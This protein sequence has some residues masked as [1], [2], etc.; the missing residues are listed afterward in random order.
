MGG[1]FGIGIG[2]SSHF[3][4]LDYIVVTI[5]L[6]L[7]Y[8]LGITLL[9]DYFRI[10]RQA[11]HDGGSWWVIAFGGAVGLVLMV[12]QQIYRPFVPAE[13]AVE[14]GRV[15]PE[16]AALVPL[17]IIIVSWLLVFGI[18]L[19]SLVFGIG[20]SVSELSEH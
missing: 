3:L 15:L 16:G 20:I 12:I 1:I 4:L 11:P 10:L 13:I 17:E 5:T 2:L 18:A 8:C 7:L 9:I 19:V 6:C 14:R